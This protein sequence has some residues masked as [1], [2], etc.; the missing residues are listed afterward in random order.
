M[1]TKGNYFDVERGLQIT[2]FSIYYNKVNFPA[3]HNNNNIVL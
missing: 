1:L 2:K 3:K